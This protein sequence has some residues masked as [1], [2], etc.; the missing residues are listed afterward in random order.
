MLRK[1]QR[2]FILAAMAAFGAVMVLLVAGINL[3]NY[4]R[5]AAS[6]DEVLD[7]IY[8]YDRMTTENPDMEHPPISEMPWAGGP[9]TEFTKRFFIVR[10]D[11]DG[12]VLLFARDYI[13]SIDESAADSY[14]MDIL[15]RHDGRG[16]YKDYRYL[17]R[18]E[19][20]NL[21]IIFL[22]ISDA[23]QF[24]T[25]LLL[26]SV[27][28]GLLSF[29]IVFLLVALFSRQAIQ[30]Y[31]KNIERQKRFI[32]DASHE[33][34]TPLTSIATS[35]DIAAMEYEG[36]EWIEN[37]RNQTARLTRLVNNLIT[38]SRLDEELPFPEISSFSL[39]DAVWETAEPFAAM[40]RAKGKSYEQVIGDG[41]NFH[42]DRTSIQQM[43]SI[44]LDNAVK[45]SDDGGRIRLT[46]SRRHGK[47]FL[48]V[49]NTCTLPEE[50][51]LN[52]LF[53]RFYRPDESRSTDTG[54]FGIGLSIARTIAETHG[55]ALKAVSPDGRS[56]LFQAIL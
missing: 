20:E 41:I 55:G 16:Y 31:I 56:I 34:K 6:Q 11:A 43:L 39:S 28:T 1:L 36:D 29:L 24:R 3:V 17:I 47:I 51:D 37:I 4:F 8:E 46:L 9:E 26:V 18:E 10:C 7:G 13:S 52:R 33:L 12:N 23:I 45:Y 30:P 42:G 21:I 40:A 25:T 5:M 49:F 38:L 50:R 44:L 22:N 32:T 19:G 54:G 35:A 27:L 2:R 14:T 48:E 15:K 53:D